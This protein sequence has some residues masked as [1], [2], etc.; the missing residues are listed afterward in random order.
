MS[1]MSSSALSSS[2]SMVIRGMTAHNKHRPV[3]CISLGEQV[4]AMTIS[5]AIWT[6]GAPLTNRR[7]S[8]TLLFIRSR[9]SRVF[10]S[11]MLLDLTSSL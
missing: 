6:L 10:R 1:T 9:Y 5:P 11:S 7:F 8:K 3:L 4:Q 2:S